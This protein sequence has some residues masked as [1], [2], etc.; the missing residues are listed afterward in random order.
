MSEPKRATES[1]QFVTGRGTLEIISL[2][3]AADNATAVLY[4]GDSILGRFLFSM[5]ALANDTQTTPTLNL[6]F[7]NGIYAD[8][9]AGAEVTVTIK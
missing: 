5:T 8:I 3:A 6:I 4:D 9:S 2:T 1:S 7:K